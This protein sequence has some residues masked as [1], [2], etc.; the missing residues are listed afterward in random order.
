MSRIDPDVSG[1]DRDSINMAVSMPYLHWETNK[2]LTKMSKIID[3]ATQSYRAQRVSKANGR[4]KTKDYDS[5]DSDFD[6]VELATSIGAEWEEGVGYLAESALS[7]T[8]E[9]V[10]GHKV[11]LDQ[12]TRQT[13]RRKRNE[14]FSKIDRRSGGADE[15]LILAYLWGR[16]PLHVR[17]TLDQYYYYILRDTTR[18][19]NDQVVSRE[20]EKQYGRK[21]RLVIIVDQLW[22]WTLDGGGLHPKNHD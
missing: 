1:G 11:P 2:A 13:T 10:S 4:N 17:R 20:L 14:K 21:Q 15:K 9:D 8:S 6:G 16:D 3:L 19:D 22:L 12:E 7:A 18:R 5:M